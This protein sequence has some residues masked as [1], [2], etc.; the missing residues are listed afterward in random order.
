MTLGIMAQEERSYTVITDP[1]ISKRCEE[2]QSNRLEKLKLKRQIKA[3]ISRT[4][5]LKK[6]TPP[7]KKT[8]LAKLSYLLSRLKYE[9]RFNLSKIEKAEEAIIRRGCPNANL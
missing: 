3:L 9:Q 7:Q 5:R 6:D 2:L 4:D 1:G 8:V